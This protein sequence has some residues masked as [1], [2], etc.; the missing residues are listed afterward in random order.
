MAIKRLQNRPKKPLTSEQKV[1][2]VLFVVLGV[3]G[4]FLGA[5]SFGANLMRPIQQQIAQIYQIEPLVTTSERE[6]IELEESKTKDTDGDGLMDYDELYV[7]R[8]SPYLVDSDSDG[9]DDKNE[10]Y[11]G[12]D[13]NCPTGQD[14]GVIA[15]AEEADTDGVSVGD[16]VDP[17]GLDSAVEQAGSIE[18][19]SEAELEAFFQQATI[20]EIRNALITAGMSEEELA[21]IDDETLR[22]YFLGT[23]GQVTESGTFD[24]L[25]AD[26]PV[27]QEGEETTTQ[28]DEQE[29]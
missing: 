24:D 18:F 9:L 8:T 10:V 20:G 2:L 12:G 25:I 4:V 29:Q 26:E 19:N 6:A 7:F 1:A 16:L 28:S 27:S 17:L 14:C 5:K 3:G 22:S 11:S 13:P 15:A 23:L 21:L